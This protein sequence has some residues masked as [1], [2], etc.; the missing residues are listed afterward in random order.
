MKKFLL[1][2]L[3]A[4]FGASADVD[5]SR[6]D[7]CSPLYVLCVFVRE[8]VVFERENYQFITL[9]SKSLEHN[10]RTQVHCSKERTCRD[11]QGLDQGPCTY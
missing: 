4:T 8:R 9:Y 1:I 2:F 11:N 6:D 10:A 7:G 5:M 3:F